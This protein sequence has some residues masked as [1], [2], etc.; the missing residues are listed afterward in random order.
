MNI[1]NTRGGISIPR[2]KPRALIPPWVLFIH[3]PLIGWIWVLSQL[4]LS[5]KQNDN[6]YARRLT[7][8]VV[9][10]VLMSCC[11]LSGRW[12]HRHR[13]IHS[14]RYYSGRCLLILKLKLNIRDQSQCIWSAPVSAPLK[15]QCA[16]KFSAASDWSLTAIPNQSQSQRVC[17]FQIRVSFSAAESLSQRTQPW[18]LQKEMD[19]TLSDFWII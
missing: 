14:G 9:T 5:I 12:R 3:Y 8:I 10:S 7:Q 19:Q 6:I 13:C 15:S 16:E 17:N 2:L 4:N 1:N 18:S 11:R